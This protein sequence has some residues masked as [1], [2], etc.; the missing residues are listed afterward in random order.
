MEIADFGPG[1]IEVKIISRGKIAEFRDLGTK[2]LLI[3][4]C[5]IRIENLK[6]K[7]LNLKTLVTLV[8]LSS[9]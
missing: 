9:L 2:Q 7:S 5:R 8:H 1:E 3:L 4:D 6:Q